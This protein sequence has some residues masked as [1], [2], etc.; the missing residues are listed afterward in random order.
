MPGCQGDEVRDFSQINRQPW[1]A[2]KHYVDRRVP[3][4]T[5]AYR[6]AGG[7]VITGAGG[8]EE[9]STTSNRWSNR[10]N[11]LPRGLVTKGRVVFGKANLY[12]CSVFVGDRIP[13]Y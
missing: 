8:L 11:L 10:V 4:N 7:K 1:L 6:D 2:H 13:G 9:I 5:R 12:I 3:P